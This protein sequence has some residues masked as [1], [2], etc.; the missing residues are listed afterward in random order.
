MSIIKVI[1]L[2]NTFT[3]KTAEDGK[4]YWYSVQAVN[5]IGDGEQAPALKAE[6]EPA[7]TPLWLLALIVIL[8]ILAIIVI[9]MLLRS[10]RDV[11]KIEE[12]PELDETKEEEEM[13]VEEEEDLDELIADLEQGEHEDEVEE[14][15][16]E[17][18]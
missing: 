18:S 9:A 7:R 1:G 6:C 17:G 11:K 4:T 3:D 16:E 8:G 14:E 12:D 15:E 5:A 10:P 2:A 13:V